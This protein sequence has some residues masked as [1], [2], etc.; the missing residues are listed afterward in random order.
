MA[1]VLQR[2]FKLKGTTSPY[3]FTDVTEKTPGY[4]EILAVANNNL[5]AVIKM[6]HLN[7][8]CH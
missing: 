4:K 5:R 2:A 7:Q 1:I 6:A 8:N 3:Y